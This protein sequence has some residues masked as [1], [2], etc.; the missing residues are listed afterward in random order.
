MAASTFRPLFS[1]LKE[2]T[3]INSSY[4]YGSRKVGTGVSSHVRGGS[5]MHGESQNFRMGR[6]MGTG[7]YLKSAGRTE[8]SDSTEDIIAMDDMERRVEVGRG[9]TSSQFARHGQDEEKG[10]I[11]STTVDIRS[12]RAGRG[13]DIV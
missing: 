1:S 7:G 9:D 5:Q 10:I 3:T 12:E 11:Y 13:N 8:R 2:K 6:S 4:P